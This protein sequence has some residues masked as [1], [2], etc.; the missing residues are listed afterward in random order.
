MKEE[1]FDKKNQL[2]ERGFK[3]TQRVGR[4]ELECVARVAGWV[5]EV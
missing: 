2:I 4:G 1:T 3:K 5:R